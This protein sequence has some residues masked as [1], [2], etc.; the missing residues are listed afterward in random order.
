MAERKAVQH[1]ICW[2]CERS[3]SGC[4]WSRRFEP[5]PGWIAT[6]T[7]IHMH[8]Y[9]IMES[10]RVDACPLFKEDAKD[11]GLK[12]TNKPNAKVPRRKPN[13]QP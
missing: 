11:G 3:C 5:V 7:I 13:R 8:G 10:F 1:S 9:G 2:N 12:W 4:P 6:P